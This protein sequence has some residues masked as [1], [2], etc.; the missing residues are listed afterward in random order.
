MSLA[1]LNIE[2]DS[3]HPLLVAAAQERTKSNTDAAIS[4]VQKCLQ[5][6]ANEDAFFF[7]GILQ[8][9][10]KQYKMAEKS[11]ALAIAMNPSHID[12]YLV[13][14]QIL[15]QQNQI[16]TAIK[17]LVS[18]LK[19]DENHL[20]VLFQLGELYYMV[21]DL[22]KSLKCFKYAESQQSKEPKLY[23]RMGLIYHTTNNLHLAQ[24]K[25]LK[26]LELKKD[27]HA[28]LLN[29]AAVYSVQRCNKKAI[30]IYEEILSQFPDDAQALANCGTNYGQIG[31]IEKARNQLR[32][33]LSIQPEQPSIWHNLVYYSDYESIDNKDFHSVSKLLENKSLKNEDKIHYYFSLAFICDR[34][35]EY[36]KAFEYFKIANDMIAS[37]QNYSPKIARQCMLD[38]IEN[39]ADPESHCGDNFDFTPVFVIGVSR[40]GKTLLGDLLAKMEGVATCGEVG[41]GKAIEQLPEDIRPSG[42]YPDWVYHLTQKQKSAIAHSY[43]HLVKQYSDNNTRMIVDTLPG[44]YSYIGL[45]KHLFPQA[46]FIIMQRDPMDNLWEMYANYYVQQ[47][48]YS[49]RFDTLVFFYQQ[50]YGLIS[51]WR[52]HLNSTDM[53][54]CQY[55]DLVKQPDKQLK[56]L[57]KWLEIEHQKI[58]TSFIY[59]TSIGSANNYS[60]Y[61]KGLKKLINSDVDLVGNTLD[62]NAIH[63]NILFKD[64]S[65]AYILNENHFASGLCKQALGLDFKHIKAIVL[66]SL[67]QQELGL[68]DQAEKCLRDAIKTL[69]FDISLYQRLI[70]LLKE[71]DKQLEAEELDQELSD[72]FKK[73]VPHVSTQLSEEQRFTLNQPFKQKP[74]LLKELD[75]QILYKGTTKHNATTDSYMTRSWDSYFNDLSHGSYRSI[76]EPGNNKWRMRVWHYL[77]KNQAL[78]E[79]IYQHKGDTTKILDI[80]CS[81]GYLKRFLEGNINPAENKK[82]YYWGLDIRHDILMDA[83][84][85][86]DNIESAAG[87]YHI[88][89]AYIEHDTAHGLPYHDNS[90]DF[91]VCFEMIK[92][93][94]VEQGKALLQEMCRVLK[95]GA[96]LYLS[97]S[98]SNS[99][100]GYLQSVPFEFIETLLNSVGFKLTNRFGSQNDAKFLFS[101]MSKEHQAIA[102]TMLQ[103]H[104]PEMVAAMFT[105]LYPSCSSQ[106]TFVC[107]K[108]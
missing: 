94:P 23:F 59:S 70:N 105:P 17:T 24:K 43:Y 49:S 95:P 54:D 66:Y 5:E 13:Y 19:L 72:I 4:L 107:V 56:R 8:L 65:N 32:K 42:M 53:I 76:L 3:S 91:L 103:Y 31:D 12:Y 55:E 22:Q 10:K 97:T 48:D 29:L 57:T 93:L 45:I 86:V 41:L 84:L 50:F 63:A 74:K 98:Y 6:S 62:R 18:A 67:C 60:A 40:T 71:Q 99:H 85:G 46:K 87:H 51:Y 106:V 75:K 34:A 25:Y 38:I 47:H 21:N 20:G 2:I 61:T 26:A 89:G 33:S 58:D 36:Q 77:F 92:Y 16:K 80:G 14:A 30:S 15:Q 69:P 108:K 11:I 1:N 82:I 68:Y 83:V 90:F 96:Q 7:L 44:N 9:D 35:S 78:I 73:H 88:P 64:A 39:Y 52:L 27:Y 102:K 104:P 101:K 28:A 37:K 100:P 81:S 79:R